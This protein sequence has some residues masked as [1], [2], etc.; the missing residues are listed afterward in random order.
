MRLPNHHLAIIDLAKLRDYVLNP[1][2]PRGKHK[3]RVF[4]R[5][6]GFG[7]RDADELMRQIRQGL[8]QESCVLKEGDDFGQ[9]FHVDLP[10]V[11][12]TGSA[13]V[14]TGWILL[15]GE[16]FPRLTTCFIKE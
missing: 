13:T 2:H 3:A 14:R 6:L 7:A 15:T 11:G 16:A 4:G 10:V 1:E 12:R 8:E 5:V 9:R